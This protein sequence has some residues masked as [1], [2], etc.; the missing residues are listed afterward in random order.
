MRIRQPCTLI[1]SPLTEGGLLL[2][3]LTLFLIPLPGA[4]AAHSKAGEALLLLLIALCIPRIRGHLPWWP[5]QA[6]FPL[7]LWT[8]SSDWRRHSWNCVQLS[9]WICSI[10]LGYSNQRGQRLHLLSMGHLEDRSLKAI[11]TQCD[12]ECKHSTYLFLQLV[13]KKHNFGPIDQNHPPCEAGVPTSY[14]FHFIPNSDI[15]V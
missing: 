2:G 10:R 4:K 7:P 14:H 6:L 3:V 11:Q 12:M 5:S 15:V 9:L 13:I 8:A 1:P